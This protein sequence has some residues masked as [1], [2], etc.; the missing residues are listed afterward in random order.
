MCNIAEL[1]R[2]LL[3]LQPYPQ[4]PRPFTKCLL[5]SFEDIAHR[6]ADTGILQTS[7]LVSDWRQATDLMRADLCDNDLIRVCIDHKVSI[8]G[9]HDN[10]PLGLG[11]DEQ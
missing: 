6:F 4:A 11:C 9:D 7:R 1:R 8:V 10:L 2:C 5:A 3:P